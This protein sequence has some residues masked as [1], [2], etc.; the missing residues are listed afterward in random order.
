MSCCYEPSL[1]LQL[2]TISWVVNKPTDVPAVSTLV[3][4]CVNN[5]RTHITWIFSHIPQ[6]YK[7]VHPLW[8]DSEQPS[9]IYTITV[10]ITQKTPPTFNHKHL[11]ELYISNHFVWLCSYYVIFYSFCNFFSS[12]LRMTID[13]FIQA[14]RFLK[15]NKQ[16][17]CLNLK[18]KFLTTLI[19]I[20]KS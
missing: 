7:A 10:Y 12:F 9:S 20:Q 1:I 18:Q 6:D 16:F 5:V 2:W 13:I 14:G 15:P 17:L 11:I 19:T 8:S 3:R 4:T